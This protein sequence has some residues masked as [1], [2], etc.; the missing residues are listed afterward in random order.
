M[1]NIFRYFIAIA[2]VLL[3]HIAIAQ[4]FT[5]KLKLVEEKTS[6]PVQFATVSL[7]QAQS[8]KAYK[9]ALTDDNGVATIAK[10]NRGAYVIKAEI[11]GYKNYE[12]QIIV[13]KDVDLGVV[14]MK[15]DA[16]A[17][18]AAKVSAVG[19]PIVI[20]KDTIEYNA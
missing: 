19:N 1:K 11:L 14:K 5:V 13:D 20:K 18:D 9:Y 7:T 12:L 15:D 17:L 2:A 8:T 3:S 6:S 4:P 16:V 10:V